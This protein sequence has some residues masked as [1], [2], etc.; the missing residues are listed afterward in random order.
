MFLQHLTYHILLAMKKQ[1]L[2]QKDQNQGKELK[3]K[4]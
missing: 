1:K 3:T 4:Y 2:L